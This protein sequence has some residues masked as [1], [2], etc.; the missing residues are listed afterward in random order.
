MATERSL[1]QTCKEFINANKLAELQEFYAG[2]HDYE[3]TPAPDWPNL[4]QKIYLHA[5]LKKRHEIANWLT[6]LFSRFDP[7][8]QIA[9]RHVF[10]YGR[11]LLKN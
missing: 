5:C 10:S 11:H 1:L 7:I 4:Y 3:F 6:T 2:L 8:T 9:F